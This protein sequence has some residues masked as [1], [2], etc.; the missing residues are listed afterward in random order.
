MPCTSS[1][2]VSSIVISDGDEQI[3]LNFSVKLDINVS[4]KFA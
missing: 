4:N 2:L 1:Q 3:E